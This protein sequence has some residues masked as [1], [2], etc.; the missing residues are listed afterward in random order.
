VT[1]REPPACWA[2]VVAAG[3]GSRFGGP[4]QY[5]RLG[6]RRVL[7]WGLAAARH[8]CAG[9]VLVVPPDRAGDPEPAADAVVAGGETRSASVRAGLAVVPTD[10]S[11]V[12]VHDAARPLAPLALWRSVI[13]AV[14]EG[15][16]A[17]IAAVPVADTVKEV[18]GV[19]VVGT[20]D[21]ERL[22]AVQTPQAFRAGVLRRAHAGDPEATD[23]AALVEGIGGRVV[24]VPGDPRN[25]KL[26][27][28]DDLVAARAIVEAGG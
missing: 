19:I 16:D 11:V 27:T 1:G 5:E 23:D 24:V 14:L 22:V 26:T 17:A 4:K 18:D 8:T 13:A 12:V 21:R 28:A 10:A 2:V 9:V 6:D 3:S 15:A 7:D 20:L 25:R